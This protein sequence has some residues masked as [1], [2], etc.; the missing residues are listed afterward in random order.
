MNTSP[1]D[2]QNKEAPHMDKKL[3]DTDEL[4][5]VRE[6]GREQGREEI[7]R[8]FGAGTP[9]PSDES[10][11][12]IRRIVR[13]EAKPM[14]KNEV[15]DHADY[16]KDEG[17]LCSVAAKVDEVLKTMAEKRGA[18]RVWAIGR[19]AGGAVALAVLGFTLNYFAAKRSESVVRDT[20]QAAAD[21][22]K[23]LRAVQEAARTGHVAP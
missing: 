9:R 23:Q 1:I 14:V 5:A 12:R 8:E 16:C 6:E 7:R 3:N 21:V 2:P 17:P 15:R 11:E 18:D 10:S 20:V 22:A 19:A 13:Q 4:E